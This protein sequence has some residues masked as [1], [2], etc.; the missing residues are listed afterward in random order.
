[1]RLLIVDDE[2]SARE[3]IKLLVNLEELGFGEVFEAENGYEALDIIENKKPDL[4]ITDMKMPRLDGIGLLEVLNGREEQFRVIVISGYS[5]FEYTKI[6]IKSKVVDYILKPIKQEELRKTLKKASDMIQKEKTGNGRTAA[7]ELFFL[8]NGLLYGRSL[9]SNVG[10]ESLVKEMNEYILILVKPLNFHEIESTQFGGMPELLFY[11]VEELIHTQFKSLDKKIKIKPMY[12]NL[13][14]LISIHSFIEYN[15][16]Q[17]QDILASLERLVSIIKQRLRLDCLI[18]VNTGL[19]SP[20]GIHSAYK[21]LKHILKNCNILSGSRIF[22][23]HEESLENS[24]GW[25]SFKKKEDI[26]YNT[27]KYCDLEQVNSAVESMFEEILIDRKISICELELMCIEFLTMING[28]LKFLGLSINS[29]LENNEQVYD[30]IKHMGNI[31]QIKKWMID[32]SDLVI[33][34]ILLLKKDTCGEVLN[35]ML[36]YIDT[37]YYEKIDLEVL[38]RKFFFS[39]EYISKQFKKNIGENFVEYF[40]RVRLEKAKALLNN[41]EL[42]IQNISDMTGFSDLS[43]FSKVFKKQF[44]VSPA[45]YRSASNKGVNL[46]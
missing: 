8:D 36:K 43:Y 41:S 14:I 30:F 42:K 38:S 5:D 13:E 1:M 35:D 28:G 25:Y 2:Y 40:T 23:G 4:I 44:G 15:L 16:R 18:A 39:K 31:H 24:I 32:L 33:R 17:A 34:R 10:L 45:E 22:S 6:A 11:S 3:T 12:E 20:D 26:L 29:V 7:N 37:Y 27:I 19:L 9:K 46:L 21:K